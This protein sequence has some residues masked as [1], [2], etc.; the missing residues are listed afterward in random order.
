MSCLAAK[1][2][3]RP[4]P[5][6]AAISHAW[7]RDVDDTRSMRRD[8]CEGMTA[9]A[10]WWMRLV[11]MAESGMQLRDVVR[12][13]DGTYRIRRTHPQIRAGVLRVQQELAHIGQFSRCVLWTSKGNPKADSDYY[14]TLNTRMIEH[15]TEIG[16]LERKETV[17]RADG[18]PE[19]IVIVVTAAGVSRSSSVGRAS[20]PGRLKRTRG[21]PLK[22]SDRRGGRASRSSF[23]SD[24][25]FR[26]VGIPPTSHRAQSSVLTQKAGARDA[27][28]HA[29]ARQAADPSL[30]RGQELAT[31]RKRAARE[32]GFEALR[33]AAR[34]GVDPLAV[35]VA[36]WELATDRHPAL[37]RL[38]RRRLRRYSAIA[39]RHGGVGVGLWAL[40]GDLERHTDAIAR[41]EIVSLEYF[42]WRL[43]A[44]VIAAR[45]DARR[46]RKAAET[47]AK[48]T[49]MKANVDASKARL[50]ERH[51]YA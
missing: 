34:E 5:L 42:T 7:E 6:A 31:L 4:S 48:W 18:K 28:E 33:D 8:Q 22:V 26:P 37:T 23:A 12:Q 41:R 51:G 39:D 13:A 19:G 20:R 38:G 49:H 27:R 1:D 32:G 11:Q 3:R 40:L 24:Q 45:K 2:K 35:A 14:S 15:F 29:R 17:L 30:C 50:R 25:V 16:W 43:R 47:A 10:T 9:F 21:A 36:G 46:K 44:T